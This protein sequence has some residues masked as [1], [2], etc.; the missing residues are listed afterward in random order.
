M[1][2]QDLKNSILQL[3]ISGKLVPQDPNDEPAPVLFDKIQAERKRLIAAG[4]IRA[5]KSAAKPAPINPDSAPFQIPDNWI[6]VKLGDIIVL[7]SGQDLTPDKYNA[8]KIGIPYVTGASNIEREQIIIN[9]WTA[10]PK[11]VAYYGDLLIT[12]KGTIGTMAVLQTERA[13]IARQIMAVHC[14]DYMD[15]EYIK[16]F[17]QTYVQ[18][19]QANAKSMIPGIARDDLLLAI[20][21][22]PPLTEQRRIVEKIQE[23]SPLVERYGTA[24]EELARLFSAV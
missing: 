3:A 24:V 7:T 20:F 13:H 6:W 9:R 5:P 18:T 14:F 21:P 23:L 11:S 16:I 4:K 17:L 19:L 12:C 2:A 8:N 10:E 1:R 15:L 22:L